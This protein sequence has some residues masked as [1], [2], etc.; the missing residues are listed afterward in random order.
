MEI[1]EGDVFTLG[2]H[3]LMCGNG[4]N[5]MDLKELTENQAADRVFTDPPYGIN[6]VPEDRPIGGRARS[7]HKLGGIK[8]DKKDFELGRFLKLLETGICKGAFYICGSTNTFT[9]IWEW[10]LKTFKREPVV[11][12]WAKNN[13]SIGRRDYHRQ[14]EFIFYNYFEGKKFR[15][16]RN[17]SDVWF[18]KRRNPGDYLHPTQKPLFLAKKAIENSSD[19]G[20]MVLDMFGGSGTMLI[21]AELTNRRC[22]MMELDP[23]YVKIIIRRW[24]ALT[25]KT[26]KKTSG[27]L[28]NEKH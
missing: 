21:A 13:Y 14:H 12:V 11:I 8:G 27:D 7:K 5:L 20:D 18:V 10:S 16:E 22:C 23:K 28:E 15:G 17:Q 2:R 24:E 6:Y 9:P 19:Q 26:S 3:R 1:N 4:L 25:G